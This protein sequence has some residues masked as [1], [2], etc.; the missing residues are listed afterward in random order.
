M[1]AREC[2]FDMITV[3]A[4]M[5]ARWPRCRAMIKRSERRWSELFF[6]LLLGGGRCVGYEIMGRVYRISKGPDV[7]DNLDSSESLEAFAREHGPG[8]YHVDEHFLEPFPGTKDLG[9]GVG[10]GD[11]SPG[12]RCRRRPVHVAIEAARLTRPRE[13]A[14]SKFRICSP[15]SRLEGEWP[16]SVDS[17]SQSQDSHDASSRRT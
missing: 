9:Y 17:I 12:R 1:L 7:G 13:V 6:H 16:P 10:Q 15:C 11:P 14:A 5:P 4:T 3:V 8:R 2:C